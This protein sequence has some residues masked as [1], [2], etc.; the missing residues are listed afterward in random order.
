MLNIKMNIVVLDGYTLNPGDLSWD[1]L[2]ELGSCEI[3]D[4]TAPDEIVPR[5]ASAEIVLTNKVKLDGKYM[6]SVP[7]LQV[8]WSHG[9]GLQRR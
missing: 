4:R 2:R 1:A 8:H 3:Y 6:S 9:D 5:S 7:A